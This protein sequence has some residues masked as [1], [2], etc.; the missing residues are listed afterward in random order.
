MGFFEWAANQ[1]PEVVEPDNFF[2][3]QDKF[4]IPVGILVDNQSLTLFLI[5]NLE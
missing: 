2:W 3:Y 1:I 4:S 5:G